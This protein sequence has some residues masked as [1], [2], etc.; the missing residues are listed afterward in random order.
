MND[1]VRALHAMWEALES[2]SY[3]LPQADP[4]IA[5]ESTAEGFATAYRAL[6]EVSITLH[7]QLGASDPLHEIV[8]RALL[9]AQQAWDTILVEGMRSLPAPMSAPTRVSA[10]APGPGTGPVPVAGPLS[11]STELVP[12]ASTAL[13]VRRKAVG[14]LLPDES[15]IGR[16]LRLR[17]ERGGRRLPDEAT[18]A[19]YLRER[20]LHGP[21]LPDEAAIPRYLRQRRVSSLR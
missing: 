2:C 8:R 6:T 13:S 11:R 4:T 5:R 14:R 10:A 7:R 18:I 19:R 12:S 20:R 3:A 16:Y 21:R 15:T 1:P 9:D 17:R